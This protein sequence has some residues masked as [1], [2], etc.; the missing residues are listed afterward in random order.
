MLWAYKLLETEL[1]SDDCRTVSVRKY[2]NPGGIHLP[3]QYCIETLPY[4]C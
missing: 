2:A 4:L 3:P 1:L